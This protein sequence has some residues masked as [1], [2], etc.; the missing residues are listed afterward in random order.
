MRSAAPTCV[1]RRASA[2]TSCGPPGARPAVRRNGVS[3][4]LS[5]PWPTSRSAPAASTW[6]PP[7]VHA[8]AGN[9]MSPTA[10]AT[11]RTPAASLPAPAGSGR[12]PATTATPA[13]PT[14]PQSAGGKARRRGPIDALGVL[15][16]PD[17]DG[18][19]GADDGVGGGEAAGAGRPERRRHQ[20]PGGA[21]ERH[22][23][24]D[25]DEGAG[26]GG[27]TGAQRLERDPK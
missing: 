25:G 22:G 16:R 9:A 18:R 26:E 11:P 4:A 15:A 12:A 24:P 7:A 3:A 17:G 27:T 10:P 20:Q 5:Q 6:R 19:V 13:G 21:G 14:L 8:P 2:T 23:E 1:P